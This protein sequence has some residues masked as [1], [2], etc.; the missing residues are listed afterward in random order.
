MPI[1][2]Q[3]SRRKGS[4]MPAGAIYVGRPTKWGNPF[5]SIPA[6]ATARMR[7]AMNIAGHAES[8]I[9]AVMRFR[10]WLTFGSAQNVGV[11]LDVICDLSSRRKWIVDNLEL[12][13]GHDLCCWCSEGSACHAD[14]LLEMANR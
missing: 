1:R 3:R 7:V 5:R 11:S 2:I 10:D 6:D 12:L 4:K 13:R 9:D 8:K 14:I